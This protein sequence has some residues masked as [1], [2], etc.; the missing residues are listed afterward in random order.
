MEQLAGATF[1]KTYP[2]ESLIDPSQGDLFG[3]DLD[4]FN[5][6]SPCSCTD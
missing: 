5:E 4:Q 2:I 3:A 6:L 1:D